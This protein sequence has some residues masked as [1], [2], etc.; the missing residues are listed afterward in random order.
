MKFSR[1]GALVWS[2]LIGGPSYDR[3]YALEIAP[4][5]GVIIAGRAGEGFP[6]TAGVVQQNFAGD[7]APNA[8]YGRQDGFIAKLSSD[9]S[10]LLWST[11][12]GDAK[13]GF[14]RDIDVDDAG[15]VYAAGAFFGG[16]S[17]V[18]SN[19]A[20]AAVRGA[21][22]LAYVRLSADAKRI[23]YGT[24]LGGV[25]PAGATPGTPSIEV[26]PSREVLV[27]IE[28][29]GSGA[30]TTPG[31]LQQRGAG[32]DDFL[33]AKFGPTDALVYATYLGGSGDEGLETH[34]I[35]ADGTGRLAIAAVT[36]SQDYPTTQN[37][38]QPTFGGG[39]SDA[40]ISILSA[41][42]SRLIAST[43]FGG[44]GREDIQGVRF[45]PDGLLYASGGTRSA[46]LR[47]TSN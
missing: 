8:A 41:D 1:S 27:A 17:H 2:T 10:T 23:E 12:I 34:N 42:G 22:D 36:A 9:G 18:T 19:A 40:V 29:G 14:L 38:Y 47:T 16:F 7:M 4:D 45:A 6:T 35:A 43:Y 20:Q 25:E 24:Y 39:A 13:S 28:E 21:H 30:P 33:I 11:F 37:A 15:R 46:S 32:G 44:P 31:A 26:T 3:A 5:G